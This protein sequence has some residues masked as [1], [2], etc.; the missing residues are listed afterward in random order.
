[1]LM[2]R[3]NHNSK[4]DEKMKKVIVCLILILG[5][6]MTTSSAFAYYVVSHGEYSEGLAP[7]KF[8]NWMWGYIDKNGKTVIE[9]Q[10]DEA[11]Y[12][13]DGIAPVLKLKTYSLSATWYFI[14]KEGNPTKTVEFDESQ[15]GD[16]YKRLQA[17]S[18]F[19][20][21]SNQYIRYANQQEFERR[22]YAGNNQATINESPQEI[23]I[24]V[25]INGNVLTLD[26]A[27]VIQNGRTL[28]PV[29]GILEA[30]NLKVDWDAATK[31]ITGTGNGKFIK[32][33]IDNKKG[34]VDQNE[35]ELD[36]PATIIDNRTYVP[37][38]FVAESTGADVKWDRD[39]KTVI[40]TTQG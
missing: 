7:A 15:Y 17:A 20:Q 40:I 4:E 18:A 36:V 1:M 19:N 33:Q 21:Y 32:M 12:F 24:E 10:Y 5:L 14:D 3:K 29:R 23:E 30:L 2:S 9:P 39:T 31:T 6:F 34:I 13:I 28:V 11:Y 25:K 27:P 8:S 35:V 16:S 22:K 38:R 26:N 37:A